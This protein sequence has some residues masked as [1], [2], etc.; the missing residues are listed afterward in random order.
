LRPAEDE[1]GIEEVAM[2]AA[3]STMEWVAPM[4]AKGPGQGCLAVVDM[5]TGETGKTAQEKE[6]HKEIRT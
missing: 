3:R 4:G 1:E 5:E 6:K 2:A